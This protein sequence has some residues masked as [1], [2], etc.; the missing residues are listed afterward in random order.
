MMTL[1]C[2]LSQSWRS[3]GA[4][5]RDAT[6]AQ[7]SAS[8]RADSGSQPAPGAEQKEGLEGKATKTGWAGESE[9]E[10]ESDEGDE[11]DEVGRERARERG[12]RE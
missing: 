4:A 11:G 5:G 3:D 10:S 6:C 2:S 7:S 8:T 1:R 12:E 9:S